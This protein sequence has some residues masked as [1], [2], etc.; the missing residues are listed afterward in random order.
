[1]HYGTHF[2]TLYSY[3]YGF[4]FSFFVIVLQIWIISNPYSPAL[5]YLLSTVIP[6]IILSCTYSPP[7]TP[8]LDPPNSSV[9]H[10]AHWLTLY[11]PHLY[12]LPLWQTLHIPLP[13]ISAL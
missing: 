3:L 6:F 11:L 4:A 7:P 2:F 5:L 13:H 12:I 10:T 9:A 8:P 1:M